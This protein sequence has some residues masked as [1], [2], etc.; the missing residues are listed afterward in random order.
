MTSQQ[1][2]LQSSS[3]QDSLPMVYCDT[4][5]LTHTSRELDV[6]T[7]ENPRD[8]QRELFLSTTRRNTLVYLP[9]GSGKTLIAAMVL[10]CMKKLN[11]GKLMVFLVDRIPLVYQQSN[12]IKKQLPGLKV[13]SLAGEM[14]PEQPQSVHKKL[15]DRK[16]DVLVLTHQIFLNA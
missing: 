10:S 1:P 6:L 13:E 4:R 15:A 2:T 12:Y 11:P 14:E 3:P 9:T 8:Y 5:E 7:R 16:I